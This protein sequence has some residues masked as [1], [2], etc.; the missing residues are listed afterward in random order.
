M[1]GPRKTSPVFRTYVKR[2][3]S[4]GVQVRIY[5]RKNNLDKTGVGQDLEQAMRRLKQDVGRKV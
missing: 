3:P 5:S 4:G 1:A 2:S